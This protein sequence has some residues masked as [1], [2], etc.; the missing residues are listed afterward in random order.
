MLSSIF[1]CLTCKNY[2]SKKI[3][4]RKNTIFTAEKTRVI[5]LKL[6]ND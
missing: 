1:L 3:F 6:N 2:L 4:S 5:S